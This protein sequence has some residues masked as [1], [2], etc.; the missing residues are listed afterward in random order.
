MN[1]NTTQNIILF[2]SQG[3][4]GAELFETLIEKFPNNNI[5][6][7]ARFNGDIADSEWIKKTLTK[8]AANIVI[9]TSAFT[10]VDK[11][12]EEEFQDELF[13]VNANAPEYMAKWCAENNATFFH[14]STDFVF[15]GKKGEIF[16]ENNQR[17]PINTYGKS[18]AKGEELSLAFPNTCIVRTAWLTGKHG[19]NFVHQMAHLLKNEETVEVIENQWGS[20][21]FALD[22][23]N[24]IAELCNAPQTHRGKTYHVVNEGV[25]SRQEITEEIKSFLELSADIITTDDFPLPAQRP[26]CS[27]LKNTILPP[28][29][30]WKEALHEFLQPELEKLEEK[31]RKKFGKNYKKGTTS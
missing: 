14:I 3:M 30:N 1:S 6:P 28:L 5:I 31:R 24:A 16:E 26:E 9:N 17:N 13:D 19:H 7:L 4:L 2:G 15:S 20:P 12:E 23:S 8:H 11:A 29:R 27:A 10:L 22:V 18:K 21:S 25:A